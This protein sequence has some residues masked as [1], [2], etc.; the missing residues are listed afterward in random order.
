M[1]RLGQVVELLFHVRRVIC[2]TLT[3]GLVVLVGLPPTLATADPVPIL[4]GATK[5]CPYVN[6]ETAPARIEEL[7]GRLAERRKAIEKTKSMLP[8]LQAGSRDAWAKAD[9]IMSEAPASLM[10]SFASEYATTMTS[11]KNRIKALRSS[12]ASKE[13]IEV[14]MKS[15]KGL[16]DAGSFL[17]KAPAS[18]DA[19]TKFALEHQVEMTN[20]RNEAIRTYE[21]FEESGL[22][23]QF[24]GKFAKY[25]GGPLGKIAFD[26]GV[27]SIDLMVSTEEAFIDAGAARRVQSAIDAM[28]WGYSRD[29]SEMYNLGKLLAS[30]C[31]KQPKEQMAESNTLPEPPPTVVE[32][33]PAPTA[34][35]SAAAGVDMGP[36]IMIGGVAAAAGLGAIALSGLATTGSG[37]SCG[38]VPTGFGSAWWSEYSSWCTCMGGTPVVSTTQCVQ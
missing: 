34:P 21:L 8:G 16:E 28:E 33:A 5:S 3:A 24:Y 14:W 35:A 32:E 15:M 20:L 26:A 17:K 9:R 38:A 30:N 36:V 23:E 2:L 19:G 18:F 22:Q 10:T 4:R 29:Y 11:I 13:K 12:G 37:A 27:I 6:R 7:N 25:V 1:N 31:G